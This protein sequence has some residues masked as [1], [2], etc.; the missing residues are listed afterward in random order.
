MVCQCVYNKRSFRKEL[1]E[2]K[3]NLTMQQKLSFHDLSFRLSLKIADCKQKQPL[4]LLS[5]AHIFG[6]D[7]SMPSFLRRISLSPAACFPIYSDL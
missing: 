2:S 6:Y 3:G 7:S 1:F 5:E 4:K